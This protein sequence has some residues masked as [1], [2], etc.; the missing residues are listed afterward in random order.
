MD[1]DV[2]ILFREV[3]FVDTRLQIVIPPLPTPLISPVQLR[4]LCDLSPRFIREF[5]LKFFELIVFF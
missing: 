5:E 4:Q 2:I 3:R 1:D